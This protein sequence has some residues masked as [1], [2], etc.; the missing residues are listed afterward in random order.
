MAMAAWQTVAT[1]EVMVVL[2]IKSC[3][4][5]CGNSLP[6]YNIT[7]RLIQRTFIPPLEVVCPGGGL[8]LLLSPPPNGEMSVERSLQAA[9]KQRHTIAT[10]RWRC[11]IIGW[12]AGISGVTEAASALHR[13]L[14]F[15]M[16]IRIFCIRPFSYLFR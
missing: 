14:N 10:G 6:L 8:S 11:F 7:S 16:R 4:L 3:H 1:S 9:T 2:V 5:D 12:G 15:V 13:I